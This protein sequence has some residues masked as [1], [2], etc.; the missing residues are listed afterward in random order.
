MEDNGKSEESDDDSD[1][2][3]EQKVENK[4][5]KCETLDEGT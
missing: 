1:S 2:H 4:F 5:S 3:I